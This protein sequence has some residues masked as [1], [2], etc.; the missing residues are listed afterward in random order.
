MTA[1]TQRPVGLLREADVA[2]SGRTLGLVGLGNIARQVAVRA[3]AFGMRILFSDPFVQEGGF[4]FPVRR[5]N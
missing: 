1:G 2:P 4:Q 3:A 5:W